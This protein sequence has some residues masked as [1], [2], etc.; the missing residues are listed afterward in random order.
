MKYCN[1]CILP[2]SRPNLK[3]L[4]DGM[5]TACH[6]HLNRKKLNWKNKRSRFE[7]IVYKI[8][9]KTIFMTAL[10][11]LVEVKIVLGKF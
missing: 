11:L 1:H 7:K 5:C 8:K 9:K 3:I 6:N 4:S 2:D 10:S